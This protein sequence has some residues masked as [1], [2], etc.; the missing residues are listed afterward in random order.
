MIAQDEF[1]FK[2]NYQLCLLAVVSFLT[3]QQPSYPNWFIIKHHFIEKLQEKKLNLSQGWSCF[4]EGGQTEKSQFKCES[5]RASVRWAFCLQR[6]LSSHVNTMI[7]QPFQRLL[8][9]S[10]CSLQMKDMA[11]IRTVALVLFLVLS[12]SFKPKKR[13]HLLQNDSESLT[14]SICSEG[15][16]Q[17]WTKS[18]FLSLETCLRPKAERQP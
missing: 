5:R 11:N 13:E 16:S 14:S 4:Q 10:A 15:F 17:K 9:S 18:L 6:S 3:K 8:E 7:K 2:D 12:F 1:S